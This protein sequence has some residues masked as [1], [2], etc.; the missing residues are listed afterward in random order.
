MQ[1]YHLELVTAI[2]A[3]EQVEETTRLL[4]ESCH[5]THGE[6]LHEVLRR[7]SSTW[8]YVYHHAPHNRALQACATQMMAYGDKQRQ[9]MRSWSTECTVWVYEPTTEDGRE[10]SIR[11]VLVRVP[12]WCED[13]NYMYMVWRAASAE[14]VCNP[15]MWPAPRRAGWSSTWWWTTRRSAR[16]RRKNHAASTL[17]GTKVRGTVCFV[18]RHAVYPWY[19]PMRAFVEE[20]SGTRIVS[21]L[22]DLLAGVKLH[23]GRL[24]SARLRH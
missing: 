24:G 22:R 12:V 5:V 11:Q 3:L 15:E 2:E 20:Q 7:L 1:R 17:L 19:W 21:R 18:A 6:S 13:D 4:A 10:F 9:L 14:P 16:S 8:Q 23:N